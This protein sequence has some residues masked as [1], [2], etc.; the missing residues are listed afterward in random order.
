[1]RTLNE[2]TRLPI[3]CSVG[4]A[5]LP[6]FPDHPNLMSWQD[7]MRVADLGLYAAKRAGRNGWVGLF[8]GEG[9]PVSEVVR[10]T[11]REPREA[12]R[13]AQLRVVTSMDAARVAMALGQ[14]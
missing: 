1:M 12:E 3:T 13:R 2:A 5:I 6:F 8:A 9:E 14:D 10:R 7:V 4:F 11:K